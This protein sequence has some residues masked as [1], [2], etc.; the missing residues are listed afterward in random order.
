MKL[1]PITIAIIGASMVVICVMIGHY[2]GRGL[3]LDDCTKLNMAVI[4]G[5]II[6]CRPH[7]PNPRKVM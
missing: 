3:V 5:Q 7:N 2:G 1:S 4:N 6:T